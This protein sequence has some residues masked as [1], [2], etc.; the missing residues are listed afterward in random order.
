MVI[1]DTVAIVIFIIFIIVWNAEYL[2]TW[3]VE[4]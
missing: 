4:R 2:K 3:D 1:I